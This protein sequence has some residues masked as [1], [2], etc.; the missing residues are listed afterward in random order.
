MTFSNR[1]FLLL[2]FPWTHSWRLSPVLSMKRKDFT[3]VRLWCCLNIFVSVPVG[4]SGNRGWLLR[5]QQQRLR[6]LREQQRCPRPAATGGGSPG[7]PLEPLHQPGGFF[8][9]LFSVT[10]FGPWSDSVGRRPALILPAAGLALQTAI[11][12]LVMYLELHVAYFLLGRLLSGLTGDYNLI[13]ASCFAYVADTSDRRTRTFRVAI[14]E[15]C[16]G[17]AGMLASIGG[18]HWCK[19]QV[20]VLFTLCLFFLLVTVHFG[21][22]DLLLFYELGF[23]LCWASD[24]IRTVVSQSNWPVKPPVQEGSVTSRHQI[25]LETWNWKE[26]TGDFRLYRWIGKAVGENA[27]PET[28]NL[29][30]PGTAEKPKVTCPF[31]QNRPVSIPLP[32]QNWPGWQS[33]SHCSSNRNSHWFLRLSTLWAHAC[34]VCPRWESL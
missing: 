15:A 16:L 26:T 20:E 22:K 19:A 1:R 8:V 21:A 32:W 25:C 30:V 24:L 17:T 9:S 13:L 23:P 34:L 10:L 28:E 3:L 33:C 6:R 5:P 31:P 29:K 12:L 4:P 27:P 18:G 11:Y 2:S 7:L 14:L